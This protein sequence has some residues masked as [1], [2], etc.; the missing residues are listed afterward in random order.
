MIYCLY[1]FDMAN[2][3]ALSPI[4]SDTYFH[5]NYFHIPYKTIY[6]RGIN[7]GDWRFFR[8]FANIKFANIKFA[9]TKERRSSSN[10]QYK[11]RQLLLTDKFAK[12]YSR[13]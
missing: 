4:G 2:T 11:I 9:N 1:N 8:K 13:Q 6:W 12:Y 7:I 5:Y 3:I 10:R